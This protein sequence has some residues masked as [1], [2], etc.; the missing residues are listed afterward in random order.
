MGD[1]VQLWSTLTNLPFLIGSVDHG[2]VGSSLFLIYLF[3]CYD[4]CLFY[5]FLFIFLI[6]TNNFKVARNSFQY[7]YFGGSL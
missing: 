4:L 3:A 6:V 2:L 7:L 5:I 1:Y